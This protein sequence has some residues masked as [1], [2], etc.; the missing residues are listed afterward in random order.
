[1]PNFQVVSRRKTKGDMVTAS[2]RQTSTTSF[3]NFYLRNYDK[4]KLHLFSW[5]KVDP[6]SV[7][8][9][10]ARSNVSDLPNWVPLSSCFVTKLEQWY[11]PK[12]RFR[13][14]A[15]LEAPPAL[16]QQQQPWQAAEEEESN[17]SIKSRSVSVKAR[18][19]FR[20][21]LGPT[22]TTSPRVLLPSDGKDPH[23]F[24]NDLHYGRHVRHRA[25]FCALYDLVDSFWS[26]VA[27]SNRFL[28]PQ[29]VD[30]AC[31]GSNDFC[32]SR[33]LIWTFVGAKPCWHHQQESTIPT[34]IFSK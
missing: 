31:T 27:W 16:Q 18:T 21:R 11:Q 1:M 30:D 25:S 19:D 34:R 28:L 17:P 8:S 29:P 26:P 6:D 20:H 12:C 15:W 5:W 3:W 2:S 22:F 9:E 23:A 7:A 24:L 10:S 4:A 13:G 14:F 32:L 33:T